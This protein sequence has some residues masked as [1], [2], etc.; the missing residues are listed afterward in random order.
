MQDLAPMYH[1]EAQGDLLRRLALERPLG[2]RIE[3][4]SIDTRRER[5]LLHQV[6][7]RPRD[8]RGVA[9]HRSHHEFGQGLYILK[10]L[11]WGHHY[12]P[13]SLA[14]GRSHR[15]RTTGCSDR[16]RLSLPIH[17]VVSPL[18]RSDRLCEKRELLVKNLLERPLSGEQ[19][20]AHEHRL[21]TVANHIALR[22]PV[23]V[24]VF[25]LASD[26]RGED[27][28]GGKRHQAGSVAAVFHIRWPVRRCDT[29]ENRQARLRLQPWPR[30][31]PLCSRRHIANWA[32]R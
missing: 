18:R 14:I 27:R 1:H 26:R 28:Q 10:R 23:V 17:V 30:P 9:G 6:T 22:S 31:S 15:R 16:D 5:H 11:I 25:L 3:R 12:A 8:R 4:R 32:S 20:I 21:L 7:I 19:S 29:G 24:A 2:S 13:D